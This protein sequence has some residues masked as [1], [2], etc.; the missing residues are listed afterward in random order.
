MAI[1]IARL[2]MG[3]LIAALYKP[4]ADFVTE[5][6]RSL[7]VSFRQRG[8]SL[9]PA[10]TRE[11]SRNLFFAIGIFVSLIELLRIYQIGR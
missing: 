9:P 1:E 6:E 5:R 2:L 10:L 11:A 8:M 3:L 4:I 7:V